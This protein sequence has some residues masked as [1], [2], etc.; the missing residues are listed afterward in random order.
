LIS[1]GSGTHIFSENSF[2]TIE[3]P[4]PIVVFLL[5][6]SDTLYPFFFSTLGLAGLGGLLAEGLLVA[7]ILTLLVSLEAPGLA[8]PLLAGGLPHDLV[9]DLVHPPNFTS[10]LAC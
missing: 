8:A 7:H 6:L 10:K 9:P 5:R 3:S 4:I 2:T 1:S